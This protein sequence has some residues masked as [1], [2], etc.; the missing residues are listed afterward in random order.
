MNINIQSSCQS[1]VTEN[2]VHHV[3]VKDGSRIGQAVGDASLF[4]A[5]V[6]FSFFFPLSFFPLN[7]MFFY[8]SLI[9]VGS[10]M[11]YNY[12]PLHKITEFYTQCFS[13]YPDITSK[14]WTIA[15]FKN[16]VKQN[17]DS[18]KT[19]SYVHGL[20]LYQS[21]FAKYNGSWVVSTKQTVNFNIEAAAMFVFFFLFLTKMVS[22]KVVR[23]LKIYQY[24]TFHGPTL[25]GANFA[26]ISEVWTSAILER[27]K[28]RD[29]KVRRR[30]HLWWL[31]LPTELHKIY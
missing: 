9:Y 29:Y 6:I 20:L 15:I 2:R 21:S 26:S 17:N 7:F 24:T 25:N 11:V 13:V 4:L 5:T 10:W 8:I 19:Y 12:V 1:I 22:L 14:F 23:R 30:G 28:V 3:K 27:L 31:D 16:Y 18:N